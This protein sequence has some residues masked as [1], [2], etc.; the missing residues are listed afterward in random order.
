MEL[1]HLRYFIAVAETGSLTVAAE[2]R[3]HTSQPSLSR[4]IRDLEDQVG[5]E[6]LT[7]SARGVELTEAG[8][9]F[10][11]H[12]R[13]ALSQVDAA[14]EAA[15]RAAQPSK[16]RFALGFLTGQEMSWLPKAMHLLRDQLPNI[17]VTV[18]S[19]Y[20]PD[21]ADALARGRLDL[22]FLRAEPGFDLDYTTVAQEPFVVLMPS[23]HALAS[24]ESIRPQ[25]LVGQSFVA[26]ANKAHVLRAVVDAYLEREGVVLTP[27][28]G[29]D[30]PAMV[31]SLVASTRG[32]ALMPAY[33]ENLL[34]WS[35]VSRP[36]AG[37][38]PTV[39]LV[40]GY[41]RA[42]TSPILKLFLSRLGELVEDR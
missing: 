32:L 17:D 11:D 9:A 1:R 4:Q 10:I 23:D 29:V 14:V 28:Q 26:M 34:P 36:L 31:M 25:E 13:L 16:Q 3:L 22:A 20:S 33:L 18:S 37:E 5:A 40:L 38:V 8:K 15:R 41:S 6:L 42:N 19:D 30:N 7:R 27:T 24:H 12:A 39:D 35:V 2:Q 21:L